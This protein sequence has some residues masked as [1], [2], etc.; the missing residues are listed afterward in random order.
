MRR[1]ADATLSLH[2][3][4]MSNRDLATRILVATAGLALNVYGVVAAVRAEWPVAFAALVAGLLC[5]AFV[6]RRIRRDSA[7]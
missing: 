7:Y 1:Y 6:Y 3:Q 2:T 5:E 4:L